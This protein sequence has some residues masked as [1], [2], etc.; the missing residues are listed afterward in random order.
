MTDMDR[1]DY[2]VLAHLLRHRA[3]QLF[4]DIEGY[5]FYA[6]EAAH[7]LA[8]KGITDIIGQPNNPVIDQAVRACTNFPEPDE[9]DF[10]DD[11]IDLS[12]WEDGAGINLSTHEGEL[13]LDLKQTLAAVNLL[14]SALNRALMCPWSEEDPSSIL[15]RGARP[16]LREA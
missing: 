2:N 4:H 7:I 13:S 5:E 6:Y 9:D 12:V 3:A 16:V 14:S 15:S 11:L 8:D 1:Y 10:E